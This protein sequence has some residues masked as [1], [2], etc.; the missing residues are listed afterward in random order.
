MSKLDLTGQRFG[1]LLVLHEI[2]KKPPSLE[3]RWLCKCDCGNTKEANTMNLRSGDVRSC[4]CLKR[5]ML[6]SKARDLTGVRFG[7]LVVQKRAPDHIHRGG[8]KSVTWL[9]VCDCGNETI[10]LASEL[11]SGGKKSCG[12]GSIMGCRK[13]YQQIYGNIPKGYVVVTA[14]GNP[15]NHTRDNLCLL[16]KRDRKKLSKMIE[17]VTEVAEIRATAIK[18]IEL[19]NLISGIEE[20]TK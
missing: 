1:R 3:P 7:K 2:E 10:S 18:T 5:E 11:M 4:G 15:L 16:S 19:N 6:R 8:K 12:C 9:C 17:G 20:K 13:A 14:D